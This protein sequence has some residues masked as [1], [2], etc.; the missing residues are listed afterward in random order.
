MSSG[1]NYVPKLRELLELQIKAPKAL[2]QLLAETKT[3][4]EAMLATD[5]KKLCKTAR[6]KAAVFL[7]VHGRL[8]KVVAASTMSAGR[9]KWIW[10]RRDAGGALVPGGIYLVRLTTEAEKVQRKIVILN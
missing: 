4:R 2:D 1:S 8:V 5:C 6:E 7:D 9:R 3:A 10:D